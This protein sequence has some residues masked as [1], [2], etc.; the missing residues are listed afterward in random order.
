[1]WKILKSRHVGGFCA[2]ERGAVTADAIIWIPVFALLLALISDTSMMFG[3]EAQVMRV[4]QD[5]NRAFAVGQFRTTTATQDFVHAQLSDLTPN[6]TVT[7]TLSGGIIVT[8]V[9]FPASDVLATGMISMFTGL[10][11]TVSAEHRSEA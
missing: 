3:G 7:T 5:A 9:T 4:V 6:A 11:L 10:T 2:S 1:M 8:T